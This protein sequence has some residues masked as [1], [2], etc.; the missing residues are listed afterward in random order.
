MVKDVTLT[1]NFAFFI[2]L[3]HGNWNN[4]LVQSWFLKGGN[5]NETDVSVHSKEELLDKEADCLGMKRVSDSGFW[6]DDYYETAKAASSVMS[7][8]IPRGL[9][10]GKRNPTFH[11]DT[12]SSTHFM[13]CHK[14]CRAQSKAKRTS[15]QYGLIFCKYWACN[16]FLRS[17]QEQAGL[18]MFK[19][20]SS[21]STALTLGPEVPKCLL[22]SFC[23]PV[24]NL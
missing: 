23:F 7:T 21:A 17:Q 20:T 18:C 11:F 10:T 15:S 6:L 22:P 2:H 9:T 4:L 12:A 24:Q 14:L 8:Y 1:I 3:S 5:W 19:V 16:D 13:L